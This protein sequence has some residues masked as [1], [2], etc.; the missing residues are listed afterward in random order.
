MVTC[1]PL[2]GGLRWVRTHLC[3]AA[4]ARRA[5]DVRVSEVARRMTETALAFVDGLEDEQRAKASF[6]LA[7]T[8]ERTDW[9]YFP[10]PHKGLPLLEM[11]PQ[12]QKAAH[13]LVAGA[14]SLPAYA[15]VCSI[16]ALES[17]LNL[18]E[19]RRADA[20][21]DP[22]RYFLSV[23]GSPGAEAWGW[24]LE[25]HHVCL[26][27]T[28]AGGEAVSATPLFLGANPAEVK[29]GD[30]PVLRPCGE[31]ED[32]ARALLALLD[33]AQR[34]EA[35]ICELAPPDIVMMNAALVPESC[36][37]GSAAFLPR[38]QQRLAEMNASQQEAVRFQRA[39]PRGL[40][41]ASMNAAQ[42][43]ILSE[44]INVYVRRLPEPL[45]TIERGRIDAHAVHFAWAGETERRRGHY[46]RLQ[47]PTFLVE[48]D[49]TQDGANHVHA[50]W[51]DMLRDFGLDALRA[52]VAASHE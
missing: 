21:R 15:K 8:Q 51:R 13:A 10:R 7:D 31:E 20:V 45:A 49:N 14:L 37:P 2:K 36:G 28:V 23:F 16:M 17:V 18:L 32:A 50:V 12:Q 47:S 42:R 19:E 29:H 9:A 46:Y 44:L 48:Y 27:Y 6:E 26:N 43:S 11:T 5:E 22:G 34:V 40:P 3:W 4:A 39:R 30:T 38:Q 41:A 24:R 52:H 33:P 25:G 35:V 1:E